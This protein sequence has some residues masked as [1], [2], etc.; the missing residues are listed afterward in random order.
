MI[1][2]K[3][4]AALFAEV[5]LFTL[6]LFPVSGYVG[7]LAMGVF[8]FH[9]AGNLFLI[10][11]E[12]KLHPHKS[13]IPPL[14]KISIFG[15]IF[16]CVTPNQL[17]VVKGCSQEYRCLR[18]A[19]IRESKDPE[20]VPRRST[21]NRMSE[22]AAGGNRINMAVNRV[23]EIGGRNKENIDAP[24]RKASKFKVE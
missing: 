23:N 1:A 7:A 18:R 6:V 15:I 4:A 11:Y 9:G 2:Y 8:D 19:V 22:M 10:M 20:M 24:V 21:A 17:L 13:Q 12:N 16:S 5:I 14:Y 3:L